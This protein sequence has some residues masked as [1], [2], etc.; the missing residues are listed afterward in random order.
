MIRKIGLLEKEL[1]IASL[2]IGGLEGDREI[3]PAKQSQIH[4]AGSMGLEGDQGK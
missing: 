4:L 2:G 1:S 3:D